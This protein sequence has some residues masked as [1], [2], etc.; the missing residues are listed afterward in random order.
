[1]FHFPF[2]SLS[3]WTSGL[4]LDMS[5]GNITHFHLGKRASCHH[6]SPIKEIYGLC[7]EGC[8]GEVAHILCNFRGRQLDRSR[9]SQC[10]LVSSIETSWR[11]IEIPPTSRN[12]LLPLPSLSPLTDRLPGR[13][14]LLSPSNSSRPTDRPSERGSECA[15][16]SGST[17]VCHFLG[18]SLVIC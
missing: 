6:T 8:E 5:I 14:A 13:S 9:G 4:R 17:D 18:H 3:T 10:G 7:Q 1:M 16:M 2:R 11:R 15:R 12:A